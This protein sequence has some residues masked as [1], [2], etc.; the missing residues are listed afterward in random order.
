VLRDGDLIRI[1]VDR[2]RL[3]GSLDV[4]GAEGVEIGVEEGSRLL[5]RRGPHPELSA[6]PDLP[7]DTRLW[8]ALQSVGG[9]TW[10]GCVYDVDAIVERLRRVQ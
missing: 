4:V 9:G 6:D 10:V 7:E 2:I 5:D 8:A 1:V 3:E